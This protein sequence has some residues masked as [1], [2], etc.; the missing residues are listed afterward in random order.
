MKGRILTVMITAL[1]TIILIAVAVY[2]IF[3]FS[4]KPGK[5]M[6]VNSPAGII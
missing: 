3:G 6:S 4:S 5:I 2:L 1:V